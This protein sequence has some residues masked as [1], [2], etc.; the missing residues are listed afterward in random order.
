[1]FPIIMADNFQIKKT[2]YLSILENDI[3]RAGLFVK[4]IRFLNEGS[5]CHYALTHS[6]QLNFGLLR[7]V[8]TSAKKANQVDI[9]GFKFKLQ[10]R[11]V[12]ITEIDINVVLHLPV[13]KLDAY[14]SNN[15]LL[16][17]FQWL[18]CTLDENNR[19]PKVLYKNHLPKE[20]HL[21]LTTISHVFV[22]KISGFYGISRM[23]QI[24]G[25]VIAHN[26]RINFGRLI[27]EEIIK[28]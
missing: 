3:I 28:N 9:L 26:R 8:F 20:W 11:Y 14:P 24:V 16:D 27:M 21:F 22:P 19:V 6:V 23:I 17:L 2:N 5:I 13:E 18:Q 25:F 4:W 15:E 10:S 7:Q 12:Y 1:M